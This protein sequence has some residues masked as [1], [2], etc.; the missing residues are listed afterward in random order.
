MKA[1]TFLMPALRMVARC[2]SSSS[3]S[4]APA[5]FSAMSSC[6]ASVSSRVRS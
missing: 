5:T 4:S 1:S 3:T 2:L 6:T